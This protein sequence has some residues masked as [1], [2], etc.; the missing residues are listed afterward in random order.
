MQAT[1]ETTGPTLV[2]W[3]PGEET[4]VP[5]NHHVVF[6]AFEWETEDDTVVP[7]HH[8]TLHPTTAFTWN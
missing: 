6:H 1:A 3:D 4:I 8:V 5:N 7:G 2:E